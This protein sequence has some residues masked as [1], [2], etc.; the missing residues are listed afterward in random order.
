MIAQEV[1]R[2][3]VP[4]RFPED[5]FRYSAPPF[6]DL[7]E[8]PERW[9]GVWSQYLRSRLQA[10]ARSGPLAEALGQT[11]F[12][13][14]GIFRVMGPSETPASPEFPIVYGYQFGAVLLKTARFDSFK[15]PSIPLEQGKLR[16]PLVETRA[17]INQHK[18]NP[19]GYTAAVF[20]DDDGPCGITARHVVEKYQRGQ[21][22]P[23]YCSDCGE[24]AYLVAKAPGY[25]DAAKIHFP[26]GGPQYWHQNHGRARSAIEGETVELH[27]GKTGKVL[28]TVMSSLSSPSE[29]IS[30]AMPRHFLTDQHGYFG[31]SGSLVAGDNGADSDLI[32]LY[33]GDAACEAPNGVTSTYGYG[34]DL[35]QA[36]YVL[37]ARDLKGDFHD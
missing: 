27:F 34:L 4:N 3:L 35:W 9:I 32:G 33:L 16:A 37:G 2:E 28:A 24:Q 1:L 30:A 36:A 11:G 25:I 8:G 19:E 17:T 20:A 21:P 18:G 13:A 26:C 23:V 6:V 7:P 14:T 15:E 5:D 31:D 22:V 10:E 12:V 29:I